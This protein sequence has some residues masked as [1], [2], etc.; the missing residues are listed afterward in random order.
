[1]KG[2]TMKTIRSRMLLVLVAA[3]VIVSFFVHWEDA[4]A[5]FRDAQ[6]D[7]SVPASHRR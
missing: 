4:A 7:G 5:G 3:A 2:P 6:N 1:M